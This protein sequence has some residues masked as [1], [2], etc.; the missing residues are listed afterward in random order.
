M[1][2]ATFSFSRAAIR[3]I[4]LIRRQYQSA[5]PDDPPVMA[6]VNLARQLFADGTTGTPQVI[7]AFWRRSEFREE[8]RRLVQRVSGIELILP[9]PADE[10]PLFDGK[11]IDYSA[12]L[13]F[14]LR[15]PA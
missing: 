1:V 2:P 9:I 11:E 8:A 6:G 5:S 4:E 7:V 10:I 15:D 13:A 12:D 14:F 3:Q